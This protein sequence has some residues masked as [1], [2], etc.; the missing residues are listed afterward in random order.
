MQEGMKKTI[1][2]KAELLAVFAKKVFV[3]NMKSKY[4]NW[5]LIV[6]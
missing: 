1:L 2:V 5:L 6:D 3:Q 4:M